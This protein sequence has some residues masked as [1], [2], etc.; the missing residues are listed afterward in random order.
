[1]NWQ[2]STEDL[3]L[4][5]AWGTSPPS[6]HV[7]ALADDVKAS[8]AALQKREAQHSAS[9]AILDNDTI[10]ASAAMPPADRFTQAATRWRLAAEDANSEAAL[11]AKYPSLQLEK[12]Q[13]S[14]AA[15]RRDNY[16]ALAAADDARALAAL[17]GGG[18]SVTPRPP[19]TSD[20][21][22]ADVAGGVGFTA[23]F[24]GIGYLGWTIL[25]GRHG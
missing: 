8:Y 20:Q 24:L 1:M 18:G 2:L 15:Q 13:G 3:A 19:T 7:G 22:A 6:S 5:L 9:A 10:P 23:L 17:P 11:S 12:N 4:P 25:K 21:R 14:S 16:L